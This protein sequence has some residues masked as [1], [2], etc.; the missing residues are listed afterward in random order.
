MKSSRIGLAV[1]AARVA[2][3]GA[4]GIALGGVAVVEPACTATPG[5]C[6]GF[7]D[8]AGEACG[9]PT[10]GPVDCTPGSRGA[11]AGMTSATV[12]ASGT[13]VCCVGS[14]G[15]GDICACDSDCPKN[16]NVACV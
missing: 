7:A 14:A 9:G 8:G 2:V 12:S 1:L 3:I 10:C 11:P 15:L 13:Y 16:P 5:A 6:Y 4:V